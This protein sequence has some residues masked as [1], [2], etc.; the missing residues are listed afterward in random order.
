MKGE[1]SYSDSLDNPRGADEE[2]ELRSVLNHPM[3][4][5]RLCQAR[6]ASGKANNNVSYG[7]LCRYSPPTPIAAKACACRASHLR[8]FF[9]NYKPAAIDFSSIKLRNGRCAFFARRHSNKA[10]TARVS[11]N[12]GGYAGG[13]DRPGLCEQLF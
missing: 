10:E 6:V 11:R 12:S 4:S 9:I 8:F 5:R 7:S 13:L 3:L 1:L 2:S